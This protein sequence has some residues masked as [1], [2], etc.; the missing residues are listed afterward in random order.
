VDGA[1]CARTKLELLSQGMPK[2]RDEVHALI[3]IVVPSLPSDVLAK[4]FSTAPE[5]QDLFL[6][7]VDIIKR[8]TN[9]L[10]KKN[11]AGTGNDAMPTAETT[12]TKSSGTTTTEFSSGLAESP[13]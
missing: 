8:T 10:V 12:A 7:L 13:M 2:L 3:R 1:E 5:A 11:A 9:R 4:Y 6:E